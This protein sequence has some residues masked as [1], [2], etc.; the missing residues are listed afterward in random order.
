MSVINQLS[1][2]VMYLICGGIVAFVAAVCVV[3][4]IRA[5]RAGLAIGMN[6]AVLRRV[7]TSSAS[8]SISVAV[9]PISSLPFPRLSI[10]EVDWQ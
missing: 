9:R 4:A 7:V 1:S 6:P 8:F 10:G 5:W 2:P 3:F